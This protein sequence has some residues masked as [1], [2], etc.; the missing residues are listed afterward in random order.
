MGENLYQHML[1]LAVLHKYFFFLGRH[2]KMRKVVEQYCPIGIRIIFQIGFHRLWRVFCHFS[3]LHFVAFS[4]IGQ[5]VAAGG[6]GWWYP[7][8][9]SSARRNVRGLKI[10]RPFS[11][12]F[13]CWGKKHEITTIN[14]NTWKGEAHQLLKQLSGKKKQK[15]IYL[16]D[17]WLWWWM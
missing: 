14:Y 15:N 9:E 5:P 13:M 8:Q 7:G 17:L 12:D 10:T 16:S 6:V 2:N 1:R 4:L 3:N 11:F